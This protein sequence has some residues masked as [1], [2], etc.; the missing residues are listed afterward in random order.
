[1]QMLVRV[2]GKFMRVMSRAPIAEGAGSG[3]TNT[4]RGRPYELRRVYHP[5]GRRVCLDLSY[6]REVSDAFCSKQADGLQGSNHLRTFVRLHSV[7]ADR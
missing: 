5:E 7:T 2:C 3:A 6:C 4:L 1:M